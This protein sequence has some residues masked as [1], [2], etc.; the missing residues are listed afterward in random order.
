MHMLVIVVLKK[1]GNKWKMYYSNARPKVYTVNSLFKK[2]ITVT[3]D[4]LR[5]S[6]NESKLTAE[7]GNMA[8][9]EVVH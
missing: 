8:N 2:A 5:Q 1:R 9:P 4:A 7:V 3:S 6:K